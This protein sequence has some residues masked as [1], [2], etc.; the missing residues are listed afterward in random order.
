MPDRD[1]SYHI[2]EYL[3]K[4][5]HANKGQTKKVAKY[6]QDN[7][8]QKELTITRLG[9]FRLDIKKHLAS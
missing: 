1:K 6:L 8:P 9:K 7:Q 5:I 3:Q 4:I 2:K